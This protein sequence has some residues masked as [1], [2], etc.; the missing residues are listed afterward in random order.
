[1]MI[2]IQVA[3]YNGGQPSKSIFAEFTELGGNI[4][5]ADGNALVLHDPT[6]VISRTHAS[7][8]CRSGNYFI[9]SLGT[10]I[11]VYVNGLPLGNGREAAIGVGDEIRIGGYT[12]TVSSAEKKSPSS[13]SANNALTTPRDDLLALSGRQ[14]SIDLF[15][16]P[17]TPSFGSQPQQAKE[18]FALGGDPHATGLDSP[19][20]DAI[21]SGFD[22]FPEMMPPTPQ[23]QQPQSPAR[24]RAS[25]SDDPLGLGGISASNQSIND[26]FDLNSDGS[27]DPF[28][29]GSPLA[30]PINA[31]NTAG[32]D[33][34]IALGDIPKKKPFHGL[35][36]RN[37]VPSL[38]EPFRVPEPKQDPD[39]PV[40]PSIDDVPSCEPFGMVLSWENQQSD[41]NGSD[42][43]SVI[44][45]SPQQERRIEG[46]R[47]KT[48][49][50]PDEP[51]DQLKP[52]PENLIE[53]ATSGA[54]STE[55][56]NISVDVSPALK[57]AYPD[58]L[59]NEFLAGA[60]L[61]DLAARVNLNPQFMRVLGQLLRESTQGTL[62]LLLART[63]TKREVRADLTMI[64]PRENNPL[65]FSPSV[66][67]ALAHLL[68]P[69]G[70]GFMTPLQA[71][72]DAHEDLR[73]HQFGFMAGMRAAL[74]G[75]LERFQPKE[76]ER[77]L[78]Q[79]SIIDGLFQSKRKAKLWDMFAER[80]KDI[81]HEAEEDFHV[82]F[83]KEFLR[84]YEAQ[85]AKLEMDDKGKKL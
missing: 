8:E 24:A 40:M 66:E 42:T 45:P 67:V 1:M 26:L 34:L 41:L 48:D 16:E 14:P 27:T 75:V 4:G 18:S 38:H 33:P 63:L 51:D 78:A 64:V 82:L 44:V 23:Q 43:Q 15:D 54:S 6:R 46:G 83:G 13:V 53:P 21:P 5:R 55:G 76:L 37:D 50:Q 20:S 47:R 71:M 70:R 74:T 69:Q 31:P 28:A 11:P 2:R 59:L 7:V 32:V 25:T 17:L 62:D 72:K 73:S 58:E 77:R 65:K 12:M 30:P 9:R 68:A 61:P 39:L 35:P 10:A 81:S 57:D 49:H 85:I 52:V 29:P 22:P 84:A 79:K 19:S 80:Y 56:V 60:G 36:Q 3:Y